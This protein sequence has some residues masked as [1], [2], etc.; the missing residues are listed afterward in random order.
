MFDNDD[1]TTDLIIID[2][3]SLKNAI[4]IIKIFEYADSMVIKRKNY[5]DIVIGVPDLMVIANG[6]IKGSIQE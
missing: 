5:T 6:N 4:H 3:V 1:E 2:D